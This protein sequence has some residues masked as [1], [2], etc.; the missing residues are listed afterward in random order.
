MSVMILTD[1]SLQMI[2]EGLVTAAYRSTCDQWY[3]DSIRQAVKNKDLYKELNAL[4]NIWRD[5]NNESY[6]A[7]Y[8]HNGTKE[9]PVEY[10]KRP[11]VKDLT[12]FQVLKSAECLSYNIEVSTIQQFRELEPIEKRAVM[13]LV[14]WIA[15]MRHAIICELPEYKKATWNA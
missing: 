14:T 10:D 8:Q 4:T 5:L 13:L 7:K 6:D 15:E 1:N 11:M 2:F 12:V 3:S 9:K